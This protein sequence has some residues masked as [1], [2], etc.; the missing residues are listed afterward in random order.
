MLPFRTST[1]LAR[2]MTTESNKLDSLAFSKI[3]VTKSSEE[4]LSLMSDNRFSLQ[5]T[6]KYMFA[7]SGTEFNASSSQMAQA[8]TEIENLKAKLARAFDLNDMIWKR[9]VDETIKLP[10]SV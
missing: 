8:E 1:P 2:A 10:A 7:N 6:S 5:Q 9:L 3:E 4:F